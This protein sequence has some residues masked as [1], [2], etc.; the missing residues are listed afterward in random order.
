VLLAIDAEAVMTLLYSAAYSSGG[1]Y[2]RLQVLAFALLVIL[3]IMFHALMVAGKQNL[4]G[5]VLLAF[6]PV[7]AA[8]NLVLIPHLG[9][10]GAATA[11]LLAV[12]L[13]ATVGAFLT[14]RRFGS[15][16]RWPS[17][18]RVVSAGALTALVGAQIPAVG[19]WLVVKFVILLGLY[20]LLLALLK[21][22]SRADL[23]VLA[24]APSGWDPR[25][26]L[27]RGPT[28]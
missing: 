2:L 3:D 11:L 19:P 1:V 15:L 9:A 23:R 4:A 5:G 10:L 22:V 25:G 20:G 18:G 7:A 6:V 16:V 12:G 17:L 8:M 13:A 24:L 26:S 28:I 14:Y 27:K 21:E